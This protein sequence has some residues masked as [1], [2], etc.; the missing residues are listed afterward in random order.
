[1]FWGMLKTPPPNMALTTSSVIAKRP[2]FLPAGD[3]SV[4]VLEEFLVAIVSYPSTAKGTYSDRRYV[5][6]IRFRVL[7]RVRRQTQDTRVAPFG[8][9]ISSSFGPGLAVIRAS[10]RVPNVACFG[11]FVDRLTTAGMSLCPS[12]RR[13]APQPG[14]RALGP[15]HAARARRGLDH[16]PQRP[17]DDPARARPI[18]GASRGG[19]RYEIRPQDRLKL[20][21]FKRPA[22]KDTTKAKET[23]ASSARCALYRGSASVP[24]RRAFARV[25]TAPVCAGSWRAPSPRYRSHARRPNGP[26]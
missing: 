4:A 19:G 12:A 18:A 5:W 11:G 15:G 22:R 16:D 26:C 10:R 13:G 17:A 7:V 8:Q 9:G 1:M 14:C 21:I 25:K 24:R 23:S 6:R 3:A 20:T 2:S